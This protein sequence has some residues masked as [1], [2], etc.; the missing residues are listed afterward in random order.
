MGQ[1]FKAVNLKKREYVCPWCIGGLAKLYEWSANPQGAIFPLLLRRSTQA[2]GGDY[3]GP[4]YEE[5]KT[6]IAGRWAGIRLSSSATTTTRASGT[7]SPGTATSAAEWS[8]PGTSSSNARTCNSTS[9]GIARATNTD[10][11]TPPGFTSPGDFFHAL[12]P[13][14]S[15]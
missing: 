2:G 3:Q 9:I 1:Y 12:R 5:A 4:T 15:R 6:A 8:K 14:I 10:S 11:T 7:S 13:V